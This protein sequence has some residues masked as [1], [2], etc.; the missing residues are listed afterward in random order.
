[1]YIHRIVLTLSFAGLMTCAGHPPESAQVKGAAGQACSA[2][3]PD[4]A[5][6]ASYQQTPLHVRFHRL[7]NIDLY[8]E[9]G[10]RGRLEG[11]VLAS[12]HLDSE[13]KPTSVELVR[14]EAPP[15][16]QSGACT[17]LHNVQF[18]LSNVD[19]SDTRPFLFTVRFCI[20]NCNRVAT[21]PDSQDISITG[22]P[23]PP[24]R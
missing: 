13:G 6:P 15:I 2:L 18:D 14:V 1:M 7:S 22:S 23:L 4:A 17:A 21:Y 19:M 3:A 10:K 8:P 24:R 11:R 12:F 9:Q 5:I 16:I 20:T